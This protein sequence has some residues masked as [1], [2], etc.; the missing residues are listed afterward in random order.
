ML[1]KWKRYDEKS[2]W[3]YCV[4]K[5]SVG[6]GVG[7]SKNI[8]VTPVTK[9]TWYDYIKDK[10][11]L[12]QG[13]E[14]RVELFFVGFINIRGERQDGAA[15]GNGSAAVATLL[16]PD[17]HGA[18]AGKHARINGSTW[19]TA[20]FYPSWAVNIDRQ[21]HNSLPVVYKISHRTISRMSKMCVYRSIFVIWA[22]AVDD[23]SG[24]WSLLCSVLNW[25]INTTWW[26]SRGTP[27]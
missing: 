19:H 15:A 20:S 12:C 13:N 6:G 18:T 11:E 16:Q 5:M 8:K 25:K 27:M 17:F 22:P 3:S 4:N 9:M 26:P 1:P 21:N 23:A 10:V 7:I 2:F 24:R 14:R